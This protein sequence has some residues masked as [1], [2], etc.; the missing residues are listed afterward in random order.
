MTEIFPSWLT[1]SYQGFTTI[2]QNSYIYL[3]IDSGEK[4]QP[5]SVTSLKYIYTNVYIYLYLSV[6]L[7]QEIFVATEIFYICPVQ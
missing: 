4:G 3:T 2:S 1:S 5:Y 6:C 7:A